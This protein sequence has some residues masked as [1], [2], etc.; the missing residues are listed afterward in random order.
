MRKSWHVARIGRKC[1]RNFGAGKRR[2]MCKDNIKMDLILIQ[3][4]SVEWM[5]LA[6]ATDQ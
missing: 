3:L 1:L 5:R 4:V 2:L 6:K